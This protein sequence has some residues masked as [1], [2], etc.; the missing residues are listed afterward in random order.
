M[1][2]AGKYWVRIFLAKHPALHIRKPKNTSVVRAAGFN[3]VD[4]TIFCQT[5]MTNINRRLFEKLP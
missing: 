4:V 2:E 1:A 3:T 5:I